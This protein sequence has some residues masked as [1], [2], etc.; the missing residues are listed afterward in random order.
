MITVRGAALGG[1]TGMIRRLRSLLLIGPR[2]RLSQ[3]L[4]IQN[5]E[6]LWEATD[7]LCDE[8]K[9]GEESRVRVVSVSCGCESWLVRRV[10]IAG[11]ECEL[12]VWVVCVSRVCES[13][14]LVWGM[15]VVGVSC[16]C[17]YGSRYSQ[18]YIPYKGDISPPKESSPPLL[19]VAIL[20][21]VLRFSVLST[22]VFF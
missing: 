19:P 17:E 10:G 16:E 13:W 14:V 2:C 5:M 4:V 11:L 7:T 15:W 6:C 3:S 20:A 12:R 21:Q 22:K 1:W 9:C 8:E 18:F